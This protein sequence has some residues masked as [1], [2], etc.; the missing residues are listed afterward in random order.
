[1]VNIITKKHILDF[2]ENHPLH[3]ASIEKWLS[4]TKKSTWEKPQDIITTYGTKATDLIG[5]DRV[6]IDIKGNHIRIIAKY[7]IHYKLKKTQLYIKWIGLHSEYDK[8][9]KFGRQH[10]V[11]MFKEKKL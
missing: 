8:L 3:M 7:Q 5:N 4:T 9:N 11:D 1:M 6:V 2:A 10:T